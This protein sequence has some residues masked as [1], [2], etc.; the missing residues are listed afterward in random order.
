MK[1]AA[2]RIIVAFRNGNK[3]LIAGNGGS[4]AQADHMAAELVGMYTNPN[5]IALPAMALSVS[6]AILT[7]LANDRGYDEVFSRQV[8]AFG[9]QGD[10]LLII[11]TSD[12]SKSHST[13]LLYAL[14][15]AK[16]HGV[17]TMGLI[18]KKRTKNLLEYIDFPILADGDE[19]STIQENQLSDIHGMCKLIEDDFSFSP[20]I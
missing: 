9:R 10:I 2:E 18:S 14:K 3:L 7:S 6:G 15:R 16:T 4:A 20:P 12:A 1:K 11:T 13:N 5:R 17:T 8:E 19:T